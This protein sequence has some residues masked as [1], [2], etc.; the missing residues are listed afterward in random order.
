LFKQAALP[1]MTPAQ[2]WL[3]MKADAAGAELTC[4]TCHSAHRYDRAAAEVEACAGC[5]DDAH[6]KAY[7]VSPHYDLLK[8]EMAGRLPSGSGVSCATCH[9]PATLT[10]GEDGAKAIFV[11]H[12]QNDNL[13]PNEKMVR[14]VCG[15]CHGLQ[16]TL[17][18]LADP[19]LVAENFKGI[20]AVHVE[21]IAWAERRAR[22]R[23][24]AKK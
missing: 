8:Q 17:D 16:F 11:T 15:Q 22:E 24:R 2:A 19:A 23:G 4:N 20:P 12:N 5:H 3:P 21:S 14:G 6:T 18:A 1:P 13:R 10:R 7:F 9:M